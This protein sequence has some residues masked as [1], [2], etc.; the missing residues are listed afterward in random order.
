[1]EALTHSGKALPVEISV[2]KMLDRRQFPD[3]IQRVV[4]QV[5]EALQRGEDVVLF[6]SRKLLSGGDANNSIVIGQQVSAGLVAV[7]RSLTACPRYILAKGGI[8]SSDLA[9]GAMEVKRAI[10]MGQ[11]LPGVPVWQLGPESR[12]PGMPYIVFPGNVGSP[13]ALVEIVTNLSKENE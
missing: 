7:V 2:E 12:C 9:T 5:D 6:T 11:I 10:V 1:L 8:T 13:E 3:E 4:W